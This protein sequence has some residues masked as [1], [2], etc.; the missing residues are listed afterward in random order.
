MENKLF[1]RSRIS[2][3]R[4]R[5][6][7][8]NKIHAIIDRDRDSYSSLENITKVINEIRLIISLFPN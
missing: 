5:T 6:S 2:L 1:L 4:L 7:F 3:V 8:K